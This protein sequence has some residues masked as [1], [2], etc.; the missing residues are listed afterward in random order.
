MTEELAS[1]KYR[2]DHMVQGSVNLVTLNK[3]ENYLQEN[4]LHDNQTKGK[5]S[6]SEKTKETKTRCKVQFNLVT[7]KR[8][9]LNNIKENPVN[10]QYNS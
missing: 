5:M 8:Q 4:C 7:Y 3:V 2:K 6:C 9:L 1:L 10:T